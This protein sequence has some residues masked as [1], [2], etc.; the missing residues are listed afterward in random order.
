MNKFIKYIK[1]EIAGIFLFGH[2]LP[3]I[4]MTDG[5]KHRHAKKYLE[6]SEFYKDYLKKWPLN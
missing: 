3:Y 5:M 6:H 2:R 4:L 1:K